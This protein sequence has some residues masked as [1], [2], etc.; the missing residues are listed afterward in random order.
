MET[1]ES[2][3]YF[4]G[5]DAEAAGR[6][7]YLVNSI[8]GMLASRLSA[9]DGVIIED[10]SLTEKEKKQFR[11][12]ADVD[13]S[14]RSFL[15]QGELFE[16]AAGLDI[17]LAL[18]PLD[19]ETEVR[20]FSGI[21]RRPEELLVV[22]GNL[23]GSIEQTLL[24]K[25]GPEPAQTNARSA[26][27]RNSGFVTE[28]P[29]RA[30]KRSQYS[31]TIIGAPGSKLLVKS[32]GMKRSADISGAME[33]M[34]RVDLDG[35][36]SEEILLISG[37]T[38]K[39][40]GVLERGLE[41]LETF[42]LPPG[43]R[44]HAVNGADI[45]GDGRPEIYISATDGVEAASL[46][47]TWTQDAG[48]AIQKRRLRWYLRPVQIPG[49]GVRLVG[50]RSGSDKL[51]AVEPGV[52]TL[53][54]SGRT[55]IRDHQLAIPGSVNLF[56]FL[57]ADFNGD[58]KI[59]LAS[60]DRKQK[61]RVYSSTNELLWISREP[62]GG[63]QV[64]LGPTQGSASDEQSKTG[65]SVD[66]DAERELV[67]VPP[68][69]VAADLDGD[70]ASELIVSENK[71]SSFNLFSRLRIYDGGAVVGLSWSEDQMKEVWRTGNYSGFVAGYGFASLGDADK[72]VAGL[73]SKVRVGRLFVANLP[74]SGSLMSLLPGTGMT[75]LTVYDLG[76]TPQ[77]TQ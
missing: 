76:F 55:Y 54:Q 28:H 6:Y 14:T 8:R 60:I 51:D 2:R 35:D 19:S 41:E 68:P 75:R 48:F 21:A 18:Y 53:K 57:Y 44:Y 50:Q 31:G 5:F 16:L 27:A 15:L 49:E 73:E 45:D 37:N 26:S 11:A 43:R 56:D 74:N 30:Y 29:E 65:L 20:R 39:R 10:R 1:G 59:E 34:G 17:Q 63:S 7:G 33:T 23:V 38:L 67:Y 12:A 69:L 24:R 77:K 3:L 61:L 42:S 66:E 4:A 72:K 64:Y 71:T 25:D 22:V 13:N 52:F 47:L 46:V 9:I 58:G 32:I 36:G 40:V 62:Y 70:G